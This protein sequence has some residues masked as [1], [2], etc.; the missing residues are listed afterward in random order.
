MTGWICAHGAARANDNVIPQPAVEAGYQKLT[1][2]GHFDD[3]DFDRD[4][5]RI[6]GY[7]WY[8]SDFFSDCQ[9]SPSK[10][11]VESNVLI[12]NGVEMPCKGG[13]YAYIAT[14]TRS[15]RHPGWVGYA[16]GGGAY[17]EATIAFNSLIAIRDLNTQAWPAFWAMSLEHLAGLPG[18]HWHGQEPDYLHFAEID[19]FE[20]DVWRFA[21]PHAYGASVHDWYGAYKKTCSPALFCDKNNIVG[22]RSKF[23]NFLV[24]QLR[25]SDYS[26]FHSYGVLWLPER[27]GQKGSLR[28]YFD[29]KP[30]SSYVDWNKSKLLND[31]DSED[32]S[33]F[34]VIDSHHFVLIFSTAI[35]QP[36][37]IHDISVWQAG[38]Q[39]N[40]FEK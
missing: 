37:R 32:N 14:A 28:F 35:G 22:G 11:E 1:F 15:K 40:I 30:T 2:G 4:N 6:K 26:Q 29:G 23:S 27:D 24:N 3:K 39:E 16:F 7:H 18:E 10:I 20:Y 34:S 8:L 33:T 31:A 5:S 12:L 17:I 19:I 36:M 9:N 25:N 21:G 13:N 38:D